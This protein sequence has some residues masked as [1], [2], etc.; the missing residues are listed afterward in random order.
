MERGILC[1]VR[2]HALT[3]NTWKQPEL[4]RSFPF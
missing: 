1:E 3:G 2:L 4:A